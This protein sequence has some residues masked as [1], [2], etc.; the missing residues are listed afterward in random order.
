MHCLD[1]MIATTEPS[2][3]AGPVVALCACCGAAVCSRHART[4][5]VHPPR[6]GL[7]SQT[8]HGVRRILCTQCAGTGAAAGTPHP[9]V[10]AA[11]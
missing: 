7:V 9:H 1:C 2:F 10:A 4:T 5:R 11:P 8:R 6:I 3:V